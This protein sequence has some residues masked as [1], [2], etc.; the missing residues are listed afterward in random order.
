MTETPKTEIPA[1]FLD[2]E[3]P[4]VHTNLRRFISDFT[5]NRIAVGALAVLLVIVLIAVFAPVISP[6]NPYNLA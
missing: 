4:A 2:T 3:A 1:D 5:E 6:Q